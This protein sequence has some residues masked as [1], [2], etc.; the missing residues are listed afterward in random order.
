[1][2]ILFNA[3]VCGLGNNG[4]TKTIIRCAETLQ[5]MG[6][7]VII[8]AEVNKYN[9]HKTEIKILKHGNYFSYIDIEILVSSWE[10]PLRNTINL[11]NKTYW[12]CRGWE[13]WVHGEE[14]LINQSKLFVEKGGKIICNS[15]WLVN[16]F[17]SYDISAELC[18]AGLDLDFWNDE[19]I[20]TKKSD[21]IGG[22]I[23]DRHKT[24]NSDLIRKYCN[25]ILSIKSG[26]NDIK[27]MT[28]YK[29]C[30]IWLSPTELEGFH[31]V[32]AEANLCGCLVVCNRL[33]SNGMGDYATEETAMRYTG[34]DELL[35]CLE[36]PDFSKTKKM[37]T[38]LREKI[39]NREKNM[40]RFIELI[41]G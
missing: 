40:Q 12:Y 21:R 6:H 38:V 5:A 28:F 32:A 25:Y 4:G 26:Y 29:N 2:N 13:T 37:Q 22:M 19:E 41:G 39:G 36:N 9:W 1:M 33:D 23:Y 31:N 35:A 11:H 16:K 15:S 8:W 34:Y 27:L 30:D 17:A 14:C 24:K 3:S 7:N 20:L 10:L 18:F